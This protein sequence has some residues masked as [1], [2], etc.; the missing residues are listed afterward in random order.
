MLVQL[1]PPGRTFI[2]RIINLTR[3]LQ[4]PFHHKNLDKKA[5]ADLKA[6]AFFRDHLT[7]KGFF[8]TGIEH[9]SFSLHLFT[10]ASN[11][12]FGCTFGRIFYAPVPISLM[13]FHI[14][15]LEFLPIVIAFEIWGNL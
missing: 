8:M 6:R 9:T 12:G 1:F 2:G 13:D 14:S 3:G 11:L 10:D 7:G 5:R 15:V 4:S